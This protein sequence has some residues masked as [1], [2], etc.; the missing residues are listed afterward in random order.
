MHD[1]TWARALMDAGHEVTL[2][3]TY[4]PIRVDEADLSSRRVFFGGINVYLE[5][6]STLW[7]RLPRWMTRWVDR[8]SVIRW[9]TRFGV[10]NDASELGGLTLAMLDG[11]SGPHRTDVEELAEFLARDLKPDV[12]CF[13]NALLVGALQTLRE[14]FDGPIFCTLQGDDIFLDSLPSEVRSEAIRKISERGQLFDGFLTHSDFY[15]Q[16][17][18]DYL[19]LPIERFHCIP[20]GIDFSGHNADRRGQPS[21]EIRIGYFARICPEKGLHRLIESFRR[22]RPEFPTAKLIAGGFL[23][24][25]DQK[26]FDRLNRDASDL[27]D[28]FEYAGSPADHE[29]KVALLQSFDLLCVPTIY[30]E[31]KGLYVLEALANGVPVVQPAHGAF[32]ELL[33]A[34]GGGVLFDPER[35]EDLDARLRELLSDRDFRQTLGRNGASGVRAAFSPATMT[36]ATIAIFEAYRRNATGEVNQSMGIGE[37]A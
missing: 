33:N 24:P 15:R 4:T 12:I 8:P 17:M 26:Y 27:G 5:Y 18:A 22:L 36:N 37:T 31:P 1:N 35:P 25:R 29:S 14:R 23:G 11:E 28:S 2:I 6:Q 34:S 7:R 3:P 10:S 21:D 19:S 13:S 20:L 32:P 30:Q 16:Y 9:A